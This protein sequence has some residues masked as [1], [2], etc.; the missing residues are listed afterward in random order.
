MDRMTYAHGS[1]PA[2]AVARRL[3]RA[4]PITYAVGL[5]GGAAT[6]A[7]TASQ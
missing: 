4:R 7:A 3:V 2:D 1:R 5:T 6:G